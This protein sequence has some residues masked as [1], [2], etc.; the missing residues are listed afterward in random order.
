MDYILHYLTSRAIAI[1]PVIQARARNTVH[2]AVQSFVL[3]CQ[4]QSHNALLDDST[5]IMDEMRTC[6]CI[7][8]LAAL[9]FDIECDTVDDIN[10]AVPIIMNMP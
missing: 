4:P 1:F 10:P 2:Y 6:G 5:L 3:K 9:G 8:T 7:V